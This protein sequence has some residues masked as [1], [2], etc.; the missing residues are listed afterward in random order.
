MSYTWRM[1]VEKTDEYRA[2]TTE[3]GM[4]W[5]HIYDRKG[6]QSPIV[7]SFFVYSIPAPFLIGRDGLLVAMS[8]DLRGRKLI[9]TIERALQAGPQDPG[10]PQGQEGRKP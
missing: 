3:S 6:F 2:W 10:P 8:D 4:T 9:Q 7:T 5:R 1:R